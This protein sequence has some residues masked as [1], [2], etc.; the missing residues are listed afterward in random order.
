MKEIRTE[1]LNA[2]K[3]VIELEDKNIVIENANVLIS[4]FQGQKSYTI[5]PGVEKTEFKVSEEDAAL[6]AEK[7][8]KSIEE[9]KRALAETNNDIALAIKK[10]SEN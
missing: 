5:I 10:L 1:T 7:T 2:N 8:G 4:N 6:V 3:V 9:A